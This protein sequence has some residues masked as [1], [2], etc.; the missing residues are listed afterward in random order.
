MAS[1]KTYIQN[2]YVT[3]NGTDVSEYIRRAAITMTQEELDVTA[4]GDSGKARIAG[5]R[6]DK[7]E[8]D[9]YQNFSAGTVDA[10]LWALF[11]GKVEFPVVVAQS[12]SALGTSNPGYYGTCIMTEYPPLDGE[13]GE[14]K[15]TKISLPVTG[16]IGRDLT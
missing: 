8:F 10:L 1:K 16:K 11:D 3:I 13:I 6:D 15:M 4:S 5:L 14:V 9:L 7:F 12:G 2:P